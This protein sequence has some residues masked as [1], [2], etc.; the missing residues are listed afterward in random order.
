MKRLLAICLA[1]FLVLV[2]PAFAQPDL[3]GSEQALE[4][5]SALAERAQASLDADDTEDELL[6]EFRAQIETQRKSLIEAEEATQALLAPL[7]RQLAPL[8]PE[9]GGETRDPQEAA[10]RMRLEAEIETLGSLQRRQRQ[11]IARATSL[12]DRL[13]VERRERFTRTLLRRGPSP[14]KPENALSSWRSLN[15]KMRVLGREITSRMQTGAAGFEADRIAL[16]F[17]LAILSLL[18]G[19][20]LRRWLVSRLLNSLGEE[21]SDAR[22]SFVGAGVTLARLVVPLLATL[23]IYFG[24][25]T[26]GLVG[27]V[28]GKLLEGILQGATIVIAAYALSGA[29]FAPG[30]RHLRLSTLDDQQATRSHRWLMAIALVI[31]LDRVLVLGGREIGFS[32]DALAVLNAGL[33][34]LGGISLMLFVRHARL[35]LHEKTRDERAAES[36][37][38]V[39][40]PATVAERLARGARLVARIISILAP[41]LA[42]IGYFGASRF[43]F[44]PPVFSGAL[45]CVCILIYDVVAFGS[46]SAQSARRSGL[47]VD[48]D[49]SDTGPS[50]FGV[51]PVFVGFLLVLAALPLLAI[52]WGADT[53]DLEA[54]WARILEGFEIGDVRLSPVDFLLSI[55]VFMIGYMLTRGIQS[56]L[57]RSVLP[58]TRLDLGAQSAVIAG[59]G[60]VGI[61]I[62]ALVAISTTGLDLSN[63]AI[64]AG[65]LSVGIG[66]GLQN[67]VNNFVSGI[68]LLIERPIK[69]GDWVEISGVHGTV[70]QV[71]VRSTEIQ[72]FDRSTMFVPNADLISGTV[73]N[74][75]H[76][77]AMGRLIVQ[78]GVAYGTDARRVEKILLEIARGHP[79]LLRRPE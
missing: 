44:Y 10:E 24:L 4:Q 33:L 51:V 17:I 76:G 35:G 66:F 12:N 59:I 50:P 48:V 20:G 34:V 18:L 42:L 69:A 63:I 57:R 14:M 64:V 47:G 29:Y 53:T 77:N 43:V 39:I 6:D 54:V 9:G 38:G 79:S 1:F 22:K 30:A 58:L 28:F 62:A 65:A 41:L 26:S 11:A 45:I 7:R 60:Y 32:I 3:A 21:P 23:L 74:W 68:I 27:P 55:I 40:P 19:V 61:T 16:P 70:Q 31:A 15:F 67:I 46:Q 52:I 49:S 2:A 5:F 36:E 56:V 75:T 71:N 78:V 73:T 13:N 72:T 37:D 25:K 8:I